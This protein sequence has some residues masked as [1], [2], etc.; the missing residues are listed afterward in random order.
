MPH[1]RLHRALLAAAGGALAASAAAQSPAPSPAPGGRGH[2]A[3]TLVIAAPRVG[4]YAGTTVPLGA[5]LRLRGDTLPAPDARV[6]WSS[7]RVDR[8]WV[9]EGGVLVL[10]APGKVTLTARAGG[11]ESRLTLEVREHPARDVTLDSDAGAI[12][13]AGEEVRFTAVARDG[14]GHEI[15]D[16]PVHFAISARGIAHAPAATIDAAGRFVAREPGLYTV[17]AASGHAATTRTILVSPREGSYA[18]APEAAV[19]RLEI[20]DV[21]YEAIAGTAIPLRARA[22]LEG[23]REPTSGAHVTWASSDARVAQVDEHGVVAFAGPGRVTITAR[24]GGRTATRKFTVRRDGAAHI[25]LTVN[26]G[27]LRAGDAVSLREE[28]WRKGGQPV[29][30]ARVNYAVVAHG[31]ARAA[32]AM[33]ADDRTFTAR[34][35]GVYTI[36]AEL[37]GLAEQTTV[38]VRA[39]EGERVGGR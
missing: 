2:A 23:E 27:D 4:A 32:D 9:A 20:D 14:D 7:S 37:G 13:R 3:D 21:D 38:V 5:A 33:I 36:I 19:R 17:V 6:T 16:A 12:V 22:W 10:L 8:A 28:V 30:G 35:P 34:A 24:A 39:R 15:V 11:S 31:G 1:P 25:A 18:A 26:G 29:R